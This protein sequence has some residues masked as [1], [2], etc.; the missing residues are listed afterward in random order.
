MP[1]ANYA[2]LAQARRIMVYGV[3]GSGKSYAARRIGAALDLPVHLVDDE[4]GWLPH[5]EE[6]PLDDQRRIADEIT[7]GDKWVLDSAYGKWRDIVLPRTEIIIALDYPRMLSLSRLLKRTVVR[8]IDQEE[9]CNGNTE[10]WSALFSKDSII[11]WHFRS[12]K[13]KRRTMRAW[14]RAQTGPRVLRLSGPSEIHRL[15]A[16]CEEHGAQPVDD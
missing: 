4:I 3:T 6:R 8:I 9:I 11:A 2:D 1:M 12:F 7:S 14:E 16:Y 10:D 15:V 5:W 13:R